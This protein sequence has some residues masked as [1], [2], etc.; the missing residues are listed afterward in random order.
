LRSLTVHGFVTWSTWSSDGRTLAAVGASS[1]TDS[2]HGFVREWHAATGRPFGTSLLKGGF[3]TDVTF[4]PHGTTVAIAGYNFGAEVLDPARGT[5]ESRIRHIGMYTLGVSFSPDGTKLATTD[6]DG[7]LDL[8]DPATGDRIGAPIPDPDQG[9]TA[10][11][12][13][14]PDGK[15]IAL[16]DWN[17]TLRL[18]DVATRRENGPPFQLASGQNQNP[19]AVFT[20]DG[21]RVVVSD[22]TARTWVV[23][24][25]LRAWEAAA[26]RIANRNLTPLEWNEF[27]PGRP[28]RRLCP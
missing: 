18:Y 12:A 10:S 19:Y 27:L 13:W 6:W 24:V 9:V 14:S 22:D 7:T 23:P 2:Q 5:V 11:V 4:A 17:N 20:P 28:Y 26:C 25:T 1:S 3:P 8:W 15:T 16:T 21:T